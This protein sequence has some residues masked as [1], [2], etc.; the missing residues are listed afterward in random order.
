MREFRGANKKKKFIIEVSAQLYEY[1]SNRGFKIHIGHQTF[2]A[3]DDFKVYLCFKC[4]RY[5]HSG[6]NCQND[7]K[8]I[9]CGGDHM[10][11][12][13]DSTTEKN[14]CINCEY[15]N[16]KYETNYQTDHT[17]NNISL[18]EIL[19]KKI[20]MVI[21]N[22]DYIKN[23]DLPEFIIPTTSVKKIR[24]KEGTSAKQPKD[25]DEN[26]KKAKTS[27]SITTR[28]TTASRRNKQAS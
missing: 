28:R 16:N 23:P 13:C 7:P 24:Y 9:L 14:H 5:N 19:K 26:T 1:I 17:A 22:T 3:I 20:N 2:T 8:C 6:H 10:T 12:D 18:C 21:A 11:C 15:A 25:N 27:D 4:G